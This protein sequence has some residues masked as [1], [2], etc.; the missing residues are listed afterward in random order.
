MEGEK[1]VNQLNFD[2]LQAL[3]ARDD[4]IA[5]VAANNQEFLQAAR[6]TA[7]HIARTK[8]TV[9]CDDV[10]A[11]SALHPLHSNAWGALFKCDRFEWTGEWRRSEL[12]QGHGNLQRVWRLK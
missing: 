6:A 4:G 11:V 2:L 9:T 1:L 5:Q 7:A 8:G 3:E 12:V 10:R